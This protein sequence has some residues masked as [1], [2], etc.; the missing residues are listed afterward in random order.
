MNTTAQ[1]RRGRR[2]NPEEAEYAAIG[3]HCQSPKSLACDGKQRLGQK[4]ARTAARN[5]RDG[6]QPVHAY[7]C[8][9]CHSWH[10]GNDVTRS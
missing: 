5:L 8:P 3:R 7:P 9:H 4:R 1:R 6:G 2:P 10:V